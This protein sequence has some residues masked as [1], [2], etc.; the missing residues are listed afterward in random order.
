MRYLIFSFVC[1]AMSFG[2]S[3]AQ[4]NFDTPYGNNE[5][6]G[7]TVE[8]NGAQIYFEEYGEGE[9]LL[10][11]HGGGGSINGLRNQIEFFKDRFRVIIA[12][13]RGHGKSELK[14]DSLTYRQMASDLEGLVNHL[15][16]D[17][18]HIAG[19]SDG[20]I[21]SLLM[22][23][24]NNV[25]IKRIA[26]WAG[27]L[28]PDTTAVHPWAPNSVRK[29]EKRILGLKAKGSISDYWD[30]RLQRAQLLLYQP[31]ISHSELKKISS[32]VLIIAGDRDIIKNKHSDEMFSNI[33]KS[34]LCIIPGATHFAPYRMPGVYNEIVYRFFSEPFTMPDSNPDKK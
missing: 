20:A 8:I 23:I 3:N 27:N 16:L 5:S 33:P 25:K 32:P 26:A 24:N 1:F 22:G 10:L 4:T 17:S 15:E 30:L 11:I 31:N 7:K 28:R 6:A 18:L 14:T 21:I 2:L 29:L 9:P 19:M 13:S 34:Q 12:D